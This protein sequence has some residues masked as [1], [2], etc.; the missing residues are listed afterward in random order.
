MKLRHEM[1]ID[2]LNH[3][4]HFEIAEEMPVPPQVFHTLIPFSFVLLSTTYV[5]QHCWALREIQRFISSLPQMILRSGCT[6]YHFVSVD[7]SRE[8]ATK[9]NESLLS[10]GVYHDCI[11]KS[12][13]LII[14]FEIDNIFYSGES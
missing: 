3:L 1:S 4:L 12:Y 2:Y 11:F 14:S 8:N 6:I 10:W 13:V 9:F 5:I 7:I